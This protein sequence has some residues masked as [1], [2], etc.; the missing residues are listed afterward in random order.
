ML[1]LA[2]ESIMLLSSLL[3]AKLLLQHVNC[4]V[5]C[6]LHFFPQSSMENFYQ[7][8]IV[9][10]HIRHVF[11]CN[12]ESKEQKKKFFTLN[13]A[14]QLMPKINLHVL[15]AAICW[16]VV[17]LIGDRGFW[18]KIHSRQF[19]TMFVVFNILQRAVE[20]TTK[21]RKTLI[22]SPFVIHWCF[23]SPNPWFNY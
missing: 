19:N 6:M 7:S 17:A 12:V 23:H 1:Q 13:M 4:S 21:A 15:T 3:T 11:F 5:K 20:A 8:G 14:L 9:N 16:R 18:A 10:C 2:L 22:I